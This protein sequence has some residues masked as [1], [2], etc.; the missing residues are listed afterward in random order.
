MLNSVQFQALENIP[1]IT[2]GD[3][4]SRIIRQ[5]LAE[6]ELILEDSSILVVAQKI[7][8]K[9][10]GRLVDLASVSPSPQAHEYARITGKDAR[11]VELVLAESSSVLRAVPGVMIVRHRLGYVMANAGIDQSNLPDNT[12]GTQALLLPLDPGAS[13]RALHAGLTTRNGGHP[14]IIISDSFGRPWR[15]G[16]VNIALASAGIPALIDQR[17]GSDR[18]GRTLQNTLVAFADAVTAG[19]GLVMGEASEGTPVALVNGL[20]PSA[21][22]NDAAAL[23]RPLEADLFQ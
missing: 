23:V 4:L 9:A 18:H 13:A 7:V 20:R 12:K 10:E 16:V 5:A 1:E 15:N 2:A 8:S 17:N 21:A 19:A 22:H 11:L 14:G 3:D 6:A